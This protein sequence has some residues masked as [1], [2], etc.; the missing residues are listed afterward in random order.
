MTQ[1][2]ASVRWTRGNGGIGAAVSAALARG[3]GDV[4]AESPHRRALRITTPDRFVCVKHFRVGTS[5]HRRREHVKA[6]IGRAPA[7]R[8]WRALA[9]L[10]RIGAPVPEPLA[11][12]DSANGDRLLAM[13]WVPGVPLLA[14]LR[15]AAPRAR[16]ELLVALG[17]EIE[18]I[19]A[20]GWAHGD[21][22]PGN[23]LVDGGRIVLLDWQRA[24]PRARRVTRAHDLARLE[25][26]L[27]PF[28]A[29]TD[30]I[31]L[32]AA[33]LGHERP[34]AA[35]E[36]AALRAAGWRA[37]RRA[38]EFARRRTG[39][40]LRAGGEI[41]GV[42]RGEQH[43]LRLRTFDPELL[44][45][46]IAAHE[47][48][49]AA[50][51][52]RVLKNDRRA[53][54]TAHTLRGQALVVKEAPWRGLGRAL[55]D[56]VRGSAARRAWC[57]GH[58][59]ALRR[60]GVALPQAWL[61]R[62]RAGIPVGSWVVLEDLRPGIPA[63]F[64]LERGLEAD[65]VLDALVRLLIELH[66]CGVDHGDLQGTHVFLREGRRGFEARLIDLEAVR[67]RSSLS[68]TRRIQA[69]AELNASLP[70]GFDNAARCRAWKR[71]T[72]AL[73]W[74]SGAR[75]ARDRVIDASLA[76]RHRWTG[77]DPSSEP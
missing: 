21:L 4:L 45:E 46:L 30:R 7:D 62:R 71:Y 56:T 24:Q 36:R 28:V 59:I 26:A 67:F 18:R 66:R 52:E 20:S 14:A 17:R 37:D 41:V 49:L 58:G 22:H 2:P 60:I 6:R 70:D 34:F 54:V 68:E 23:V 72:Q 50:R 57:A 13:A 77:P 32:R 15:A 33:A 12:G 29:R 69:L 25:H 38:D 35:A 47:A 5:Q 16:R 73:P 63:A 11:L 44:S 10:H 51:D 9:A 42:E 3:E 19:H 76:R 43:G 48:A 75:R 27:A 74:P 65:A 53:R 8:E 39:R 64:A 40:L 1:A 61:E 31:R 55:A